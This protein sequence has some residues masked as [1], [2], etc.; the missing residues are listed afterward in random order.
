[1]VQINDR[2]SYL[3]I[4]LRSETISNSPGVVCCL[5]LCRLWDKQFVLG[6]SLADKDWR[7]LRAWYSSQQ[8]QAGPRRHAA[9]L[10]TP[11]SFHKRPRPSPNNS[12][13]GDSTWLN[14]SELRPK[15]TRA[16]SKYIS[17]L[18][19]LLVAWKMCSQFHKV[20]PAFHPHYIT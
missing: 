20:Y 1:M 11:L 6:R 2:L 3:R 10:D 18:L 12:V 13:Q 16:L 15:V 9:E 19:L 14:G 8:R 17:L 4:A 7:G 5:S